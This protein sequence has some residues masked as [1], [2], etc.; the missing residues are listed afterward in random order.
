MATCLAPLTGGGT[1]EAPQKPNTGVLKTLSEIN[2]CRAFT[3]AEVLITL[4]IIGIVAVMTMPSVIANH[5]KKVFSAKIKKAYSL[6]SQAYSMASV[7]N[8]D[9]YAWSYTK[10]SRDSIMN[11]Y[12]FS[13]LKGINTLDDPSL[14]QKTEEYIEEYAQ[15]VGSGGYHADCFDFKKKI[16]IWGGFV[17]NDGY[18]IVPICHV[19]G[20]FIQAYIPSPS[21][22]AYKHYTELLIDVN[23]FQKPNILGR[24]IFNFMLVHG[25]NVY[26]YS[27]EQ[28]KKYAKEVSL[29]A[30]DTSVSDVTKPGI[31][32]SNYGSKS[33][34]CTA[35]YRKGCSKKLME[36]GWEFKKDYPW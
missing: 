8:G 25:V 24:D 6:L 17:T 18:L 15:K 33:N 11:K 10:N 34:G 16:K 4:A 28:Q 27:A 32:P 30:K 13:E 22:T 35:T 3:L 19:D 36:D 14:N 29:S 9:A 12:I 5:Q 23:G 7:K 26:W 1:L 20:D 2:L 21:P 31:Y